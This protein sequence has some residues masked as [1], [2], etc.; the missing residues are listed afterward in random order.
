VHVPPLRERLEDLRL[1]SE[2]FLARTAARLERPIEGFTSGAW[3]RLR[4]Y[5]W[6]GNVRQLE[7]AIERACTMSPDPLIDIEHL[8]DDIRPTQDRPR[9][10]GAGGLH[11]PEYIRAVVQRV[12]SQR[13]AAEELG[14]SLATLK[15]RLRAG[16]SVA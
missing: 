10:A 6:P 14:L 11:D 9:H 16:G 3:A 1:L 15:R 7:H 5:H 8:P 12:G 2:Y 4:G 13:R